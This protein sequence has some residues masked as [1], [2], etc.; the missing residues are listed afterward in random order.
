MPNISFTHYISVV[1]WGLLLSGLVIGIGPTKPAHAQTTA[2][3]DCTGDYLIDR[4]LTANARW[5]FCWEHRNR[6]GILFHN[7][8]YTSPDGTRRKVLRQASLA[9]IHTPYDDNSFRYH[10]VTDLGLGA[11]QMVALQPENCPDGTLLAHNNKSVLCERVSERGYIYKSYSQQRHGEY[12]SLYSVSDLG[13]QSMVIRWRFYDDGSIEPSVG[14]TGY[15]NHWGND[16]QFGWSID[17][18]NT[19]GLGY[20]NNYY[21][22]FDF[23]LGG[24]GDNDIVEELNL[25]PIDA[26]SRKSLSIMPLTQEQGRSIDPQRKRSW[27]I[28]DALITNR[29]GH[30]ISYHLEPMNVGHRYIGPDSE[31]WTQ[32][33][34]YFTKYNSCEQFASHN[35]QLDSCGENVAEFANG[36]DINSAD[37]VVWYRTS[38]HHLPSSEYQPFIPIHWDSLLLM[39]RDWTATNEFKN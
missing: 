35:P 21:W 14:S 32:H 27:R 15:L 17:G 23:D 11:S 6:E 13:G 25:D 2:T 19:V 18:S 29:D 7:I 36:E 9:Q 28:R 10:Y 33:D 26:G 1:L 39:P 34:I 24:N 3:P 31:P 20:T 37:L 30:P 16:I 22:R 12:L 5:E 38:Y 8:F 4:T